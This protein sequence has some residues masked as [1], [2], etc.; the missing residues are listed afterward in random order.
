MPIYKGGTKIKELY[1]G[2]TKIK[3]LYKGST[4]VFSNRLPVGTVIF[5]SDVNGT[6]TVAIPETRN[7]AIKLVGGGAAGGGLYI[8]GTGAYVYGTTQIQKGSYTVVVGKRGEGGSSTTPKAGGNTT[9][10]S[11]TAKGGP[12]TTTEKA[13]YTVTLPGLVGV[14][15]NAGRSASA[16]TI[17]SPYPPYGRASNFSSRDQ[18]NTDGY[19][20]IVTA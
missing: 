13:G 19:I 18:K 5:E 17:D 2:G 7:Y 14:L 3:E 9:A 10:F 6:Y 11:Q 20:S 4:K 16:G 8:A 15:G 1:I 12:S